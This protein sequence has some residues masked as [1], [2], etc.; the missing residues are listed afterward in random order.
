MLE[1][2]PRSRHQR[3][4][5]GSNGCGSPLRAKT[6]VMPKKKA[7]RER[8]KDGVKAREK[9]Y[10]LGIPHFFSFFFFFA[11]KGAEKEAV[12]NLRE[13]I[14]CFCVEK[15]RNG[16]K[17]GMCRGRQRIVGIGL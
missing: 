6:I 9:F 5:D 2:T 12:N 10:V 11:E 16:E 3:S 13:K 14:S 15:K 8:G 7:K 1:L 17:W 4:Y